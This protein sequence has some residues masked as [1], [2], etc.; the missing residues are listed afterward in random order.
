M[1]MAIAVIAFSILFVIGIVVYVR[2]PE[3]VSDDDGYGGE[4]DA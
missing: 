3:E 4:Y 2:W 1:T